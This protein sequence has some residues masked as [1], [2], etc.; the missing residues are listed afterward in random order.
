MEKIAADEKGIDTNKPK[1]SN[2]DEET[3]R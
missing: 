1:S 2:V 3:L